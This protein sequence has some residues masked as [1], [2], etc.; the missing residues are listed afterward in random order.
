MSPRRRPAPG[1]S[2]RAAG[3]SSWP[4]CPRPA[5]STTWPTCG[6]SAAPCRPSTPPG[7]RTP[8]PN[9]PS[10]WGVKP[11][12]IPSLVRRHR[13]AAVGNGK[14]RRYPRETAEALRALRARGRSVKTSNLY[15]DAVK[16]FAAGLVL[17][18][19]TPDNPLAHLAGGNV[20]LD[21]R[22]D[23]RA[24][25]LGELR[26]VLGAAACSGVP[27][28]GLSGPDRLV[29]YLAACATGFRAEELACL[30]P[31]SFDLGAEPP[32]A[33][34]GAA[35]TKNGRGATQPLPPDVAAALGDYLRG[36]PAGVPLWPGSWW[37][38]AADMLRI[39]LDA[40]GVAYAV[41]GPDGP[42][43]ADFQA[44]RHSYVALLEKSG[45]TL[46]EAMQL[47]RHSD[48][49]LTMA[50]YGRAQLH[51][52]GQAVGRLPTLVSGPTSEGATLAATGTDGKRAGVFPTAEVSSLRSACASGDGGRGFLSV[53]DETLAGDGAGEGNEEPRAL[54]GVEGGCE[55]VTVSERSSPTRTRT[56]NKPVNR[57]FV[58]AAEKLRRTLP[59]LK[60][61]QIVPVCKRVRRRAWNCGD[62][63]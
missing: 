40:A 50:V 23:R 2:S 31:E 47:A 12:A 42:L 13:L 20:K 60:I 48:P 11:S 29:L 25:P 43:Y 32:L 4:T 24:L 44:L 54:Q 57:Q 38:R 16:Q 18:R 33:V 56:W 21:R 52:L 62:S 17:D 53:A 51:D 45:A 46:K 61:R 58:R 39:D 9:W 14:A 10:W 63:R 19:R 3:S 5:S 15:L 28:R 6:S 36:R 34:L 27:F 35:E 30:H 37:K 41:E 26:A 49:K 8:G 22:H 1:A 55:P 7:R 59:A